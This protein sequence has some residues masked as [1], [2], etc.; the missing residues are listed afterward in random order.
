MGHLTNVREGE[1]ILKTVVQVLEETVE[2]N[3]MKRE[4]RAFPV[5]GTASAPGMLSGFSQHGGN[6]RASLKR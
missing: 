6:F 3:P 2:M 5:E 4:G 1:D